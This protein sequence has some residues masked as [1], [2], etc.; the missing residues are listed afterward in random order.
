MS[1]SCL[2]LLKELSLGL[3][4]AAAEGPGF[5]IGEDG[6]AWRFERHDQDTWV[7]ARGGHALEYSVTVARVGETF[8]IRGRLTNTGRAPVSGINLLEPLRIAFDIPEQHW[9]HQYANGGTTEQYYPP[10]AFRLHEWS[11]PR[12]RLRIESHHRGNSSNLHLP[13]LLSCCSTAPDAEGFF[14]ALEWSG[15]WYITFD[16]G[17]GAQGIVSAGIG[18]ANMVLEPGETLEMPAAHIGFFAGGPDGGTNALRRYLYEHVCPRYAGARVLPRVSYDH[19]FG[20]GNDLNVDILKRQAD[21]A[22]ELGVEMFVVDAGWFAGGFPDGVGNWELIDKGKFPGGLEAVAEYVRTRGMRMGLWFEPER[23][24][25]ESKLY[26]DHPDWFVRHDYGPSSMIQGYHIDLSIRDAQDYLIELIGGMIRRLELKWTRWDYNIDPNVL[27][28]LR[29]P[30]NKLQLAYYRGLYR[31][32]DTL[33]AE[34]P[35]WMV[36]MCAGGGRRIDL[37]TMRRAHTYWIS[38]HTEQAPIC[39]CMQAR[40]N[41][42]VP[43]HL[44]N[45]SVPAGCSRGDARVDATTFLSRMLGKLAMDGRIADWSVE[46]TKCAKTWV[47]QFKAIRHLLIQDFFQLLPQPSTV[48]DWDAVQFV[49]HD[50]SE[51]VVFV[52]AGTLGGTRSIVLKGLSDSHIYTVSRAPDGDSQTFTGEQLRTEGVRVTLQ[53]QEGALLRVQQMPR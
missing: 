6:W 2:T 10:S 23:A 25:L 30:T 14:C 17:D 11:C 26:K 32:L 20:I 49:A 19:W 24:G 7:Y 9:R 28:R 13:I 34:F 51:A 46:E 48:E 38:D 37:G 21:R 16:S 33:M 18:A 35:E 36:E 45:S 29:D 53:S 42:F 40:A 44:L 3:P 43:G 5:R 1:A 4:N 12:E 47:S 27:W 39:R 52:F 50:S 15:T 41:R 22:A 31:V 8:V